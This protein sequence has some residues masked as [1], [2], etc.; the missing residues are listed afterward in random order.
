MK[1]RWFFL[2]IFAGTSIM[3][4]AQNGP[5]VQN[6]SSGTAQNSFSVHTSSATEMVKMREAG[7]DSAVIRS[8]IQTLQVPYKATA[9][10]ILYLHEHKVP[11][12]LVV[13]WIKKGGELVGLVAQSRA[14]APG[15]QQSA[16]SPDLVTAAAPAPLPVQVQQAQPQVV[17]QTAPPT[18]VY[19]SPS[20]VYSDPYWYVPPVSIGFSWGWGFPRWGGHGGHFGHGGY[21]G[22]GHY[23]YAT[24]HGGGYRGSGWGGHGGGGMH[25]G[26]HGGGRH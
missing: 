5:V 25:G 20:Y 22:F 19:S 11:D 16:Q 7:V 23:N 24:Y 10:D 18:V 13:E 17:Y 8:Y 1:S 12:D 14:P 9:D 26:G 2:S 4:L 6:S 3:A 15:P 21:R